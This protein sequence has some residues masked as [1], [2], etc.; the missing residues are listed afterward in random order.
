MP[1]G[2]HA[3]VHEV[4]HPAAVVRQLCRVIGCRGLDVRTGHRHE[5][6][7]VRRDADVIH[8]RRRETRRV[9]DRVAVG[10]DPF[11]DLPEVQRPPGEGAPRQD[12]QRRPRGAA[13]A[14]RHVRDAAHLHGAGD[15]LGQE[16]SRGHGQL[17]LGDAE[18]V[19]PGHRQTC[20]S[21]QDASAS[22]APGPQVPRS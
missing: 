11:V 21:C 17:G 7:M 14:Q 22:A 2:S 20:G 6:Q 10:G 1:V 19:A 3:E 16:V 4:E 18:F 8:Q 15:R 9:A 5:M 12:P 13:T